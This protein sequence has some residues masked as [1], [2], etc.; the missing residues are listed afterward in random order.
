[1]I[2]PSAPAPVAKSVDRAAGVPP[3]PVTTVA[4]GAQTSNTRRRGSRSAKADRG[5]RTVEGRIRV[6]HEILDHQRER[7]L[8]LRARDGRLPGAER[9]AAEDELIAHNM[10]LVH[11]L[12]NRYASGRAYMEIS[13][14]VST[15]E[16]LV[17]EGLI[18]LVHALRRYDP[19]H[20][21]SFACYAAR[22]IRQRVRAAAEEGARPIKLTNN[23]AA[24]LAKR[25]RAYSELCVALGR[26][27]T[28]EELAEQLG[29]SV[30]RT[31]SVEA[32]AR[33]M[34]GLLAVPLD[35]RGESGDEPDRPLHEKLACE[36]PA[37]DEDPLLARVGRDGLLAALRALDCREREI[38]E[39]RYGLGGRAV[40]TLVEVAK[41]MGLS[42]EGVRK[43]QRRA[44]RKLK[45]LLADSLIGLDFQAAG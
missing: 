18:G 8:L 28:A 25:R 1:M 26:E 22:L 12:A 32:T 45:G 29:W 21:M 43:A 24:D 10:R 9:R 19:S 13:G 7:A 33:W 37:D 16:D 20:G 4:N 5:L 39:R 2:A 3:R 30:A 41:A 15:I 34:S 44:E 14:T 17:Q 36:D 40:Q 6:E 38:L 23:A 31:A 35:A 27:P 11:S 42:D